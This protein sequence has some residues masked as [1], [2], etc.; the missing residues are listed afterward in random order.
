MEVNTGKSIHHSHFKQFTL[1]YNTRALLECTITKLNGS[2]FRQ[3]YSSFSLQTIH[4]QIQHDHNH[5]MPDHQTEWKSI[6]GNLAIILILEQF[7]LK[8]NTRA[9]LECTITKLNGSQFRQ[10]YSSFS[11]L[12]IHSQIQ[13]ENNHRMLYHQTEVIS[14]RACLFITSFLENHSSIPMKHNRN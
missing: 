11:I 13:H 6:W 7:T 12:T 1:K 9:L 2:Q 10:V 3:I 14:S 5:G 4:S 8:Y